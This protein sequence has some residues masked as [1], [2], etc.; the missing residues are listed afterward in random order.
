MEER[1]SGRRVPSL[2][3]LA[4][5]ALV[6]AVEAGQ[7]R[8]AS[9]YLQLPLPDGPRQECLALLG[10]RKKISSATLRP[11][12]HDSVTRLD[13]TAQCRG[14]DVVRTVAR[15]PHLT[16]LA[17]RGCL[18]PAASAKAARVAPLTGLLRALDVSFNASLG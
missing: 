5:R 4:L 15:T 8:T 6:R 11:F 10:R 3:Y 9:G 1:A 7:Y 16:H 13:L 12:L 17:L 2:R 18:G 14:L